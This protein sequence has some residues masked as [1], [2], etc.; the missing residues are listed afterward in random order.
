MAVHLA[1][2]KTTAAYLNRTRQGGYFGNHPAGSI[3]FY[4]GMMRTVAVDDVW[5]P[6]LKE[7][8]ALAAKLWPE[9]LPSGMPGVPAAMRMATG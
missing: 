1:Y 9:R 3:E 5:A 6:T 8:S 2:V 4:L 7:S